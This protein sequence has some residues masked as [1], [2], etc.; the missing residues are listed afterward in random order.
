MA[1]VKT[2]TESKKSR[3]MSAPFSPRSE[4]DFFAQEGGE[5]R[6]KNYPVQDTLPIPKL[7]WAWNASTQ[8]GMDFSLDEESAPMTI[9]KIKILGAVLQL[10]AK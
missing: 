9:E 6:P 2:A 5:E 4:G 1:I 3:P 10:P 7:L 8:V